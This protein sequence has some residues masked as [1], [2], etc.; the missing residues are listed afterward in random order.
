MGQG[1]MQQEQHRVRG[2]GGHWPHIG[3]H[4]IYHSLRVVN[5]D[6]V[7]EEDCVSVLMKNTFFSTKESLKIQAN[8]CYNI[9]HK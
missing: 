6:H 9:S 2:V 4:T 3:G 7:Q 5:M 1:A 8:K